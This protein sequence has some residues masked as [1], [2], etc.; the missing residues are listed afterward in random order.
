MIADEMRVY[1]YR[2]RQTSQP[3]S[4]PEQLPNCTYPSRIITATF[5]PLGA[6]E[7]LESLWSLLTKDG[8]VSVSPLEVA[9]G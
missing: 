9:R 2:F 5:M 1:Q 4:G 3:A 6:R 7:S 8:L